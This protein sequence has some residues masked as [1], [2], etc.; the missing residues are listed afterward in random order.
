MM[1]EAVSVSDLREQIEIANPVEAV[2]DGRIHVER[3]IAL[4]A[5]KKGDDRCYV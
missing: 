3:S 2:Q 4:E 1:K 5:T